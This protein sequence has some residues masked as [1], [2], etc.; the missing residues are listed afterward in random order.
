MTASNA[1]GMAK[2]DSRA[3]LSTC[4]SYST[5][6]TSVGFDHRG[7]RL[8]V[9][10]T[11][12]RGGES[13]AKVLVV[14]DEGAGVYELTGKIQRALKRHG[15]LYSVERIFNGK[16]F[17]LPPDERLGDMLADSE[18]I[19]VTLCDDG[20]QWYRWRKNTRSSA[21]SSS[22][23][24]RLEVEWT[25]CVKVATVQT[26]PKDIIYAPYVLE[27]GNLTAPPA[28]AEKS[29]CFAVF[30]RGA[31]GTMTYYMPCTV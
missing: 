31:Q 20:E 19:I 24:R 11:A 7:S 28:R 4:A 18:E 1:R 17:E 12:L 25:P 27:G 5:L 2:S 13:I 15:I 3:T 10:V 14:I 29:E 21:R 22:G 23:T 30:P 6:D 16:L 26:T 8:R 9:N